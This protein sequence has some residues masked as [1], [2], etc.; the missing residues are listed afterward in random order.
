MRK[1]EAVVP[2][3]VRQLMAVWLCSHWAVWF[4]LAGPGSLS[5]ATGSA[6]KALLESLQ[7]SRAFVLT[8]LSFIT[9]LRSANC[10]LYWKQILEVLLNICNLL[11]F[12]F[13]LKWKNDP[14]ICTFYLI[15]VVHQY[16]LWWDPLY[17]YWLKIYNQSNQFCFSFFVPI[18]FA[19]SLYEGLKEAFHVKKKEQKRSLL[20]FIN[21]LNYLMFQY[22][23]FL[24][25]HLERNVQ[26]Y[27]TQQLPSTFAFS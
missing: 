4:K 10:C 3:V 25:R 5:S 18:D 24:R 19:L 17:S 11:C 6:F 27:A 2:V 12:C 20:A 7:L 21:V 14:A 15:L 9:E 13:F 23:P 1:P 8:W 26:S 22:N 16:K